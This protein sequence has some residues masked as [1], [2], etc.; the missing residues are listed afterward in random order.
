MQQDGTKGELDIWFT[1]TALIE[2]Q[3]ALEQPKEIQWL[4]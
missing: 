4:T 3:A 2:H 1:T